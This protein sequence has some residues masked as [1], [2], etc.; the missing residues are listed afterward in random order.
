MRER[1][2]VRG[3]FG[4]KKTALSLPLWASPIFK[5]ASSLSLSQ[6]TWTASSRR[7]HCDRTARAARWPLCGVKKKGKGLNWGR[8]I[9]GG[10]SGLDGMKVRPR[11]WPATARREAREGRRKFSLQISVL[12]VS[13]LS[14]QSLSPNYTHQQSSSRS[15][16]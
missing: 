7:A 5:L 15:S 13:Q 1:G 9:E 3:E 16:T 10:Q 6:L 4:I 2:A 8:R 11:P 12:L 14:S